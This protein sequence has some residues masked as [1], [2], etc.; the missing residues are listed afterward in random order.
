[1]TKPRLLGFAVALV[2]L[3][4]ALS[5]CFAQPAQPTDSQRETA[6]KLWSDGRERY[7]AKDYTGALASFKAANAIMGAPTTAI[8]LARTQAAL[9]RLVEAA[10]SAKQAADYPPSPDE[11][12]PYARARAEAGELLREILART[13]KIALTVQGLPADVTPSIS[14]DDQPVERP[15]A[16]WFAPADPGAARADDHRARFLQTDAHR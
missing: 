13:P 4:L 2:G 14:L 16:S 10:A 3:Q 6:R 15:S 1:M 11:P 12:A 5:P 9:G 8:E 7:D